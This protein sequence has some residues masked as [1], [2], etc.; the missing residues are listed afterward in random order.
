M[1]MRT[2]HVNHFKDAMSYILKTLRKFKG[3]HNLMDIFE[4]ESSK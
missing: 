2:S 3:K 4:N 1:G